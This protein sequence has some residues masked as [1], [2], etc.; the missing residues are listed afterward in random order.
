MT[1][2]LL[3]A[4]VAAPGSFVLMDETVEVPRAAW[5]AF[6]L[7]LLERPALIHCS[8][9][10]ESG[11]SGVRLALMR[12]VDSTRLRSGESN[13]VL[14]ATAYRRS[15]EFRYPAPQGDYSLI[16]DN[17]LE[18]R[19]PARVR[20]LVEL[21]FANAQ[22]PPEY[23]PPGRKALVVVAS[24]LFFAGVV[25]YATQKLRRAVSERRAT[26]SSR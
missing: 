3:L 15:G 14:A 5:R 4:L 12:R 19:G 18:G 1:L 11:G 23:L 10:V 26:R 6:D 17:S 24:I 9:S 13:H 20:V 25:F 7:E 8:F 22:P 2:A 16:V 21:V